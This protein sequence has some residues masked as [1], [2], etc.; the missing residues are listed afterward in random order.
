[1]LAVASGP[2][3]GEYSVDLDTGVYT[4]A[5]ADT[6]LGVLISYSYSVAADGQTFSISNTPMGNGPILSLYLPS[7]YESTGL[8]QL[9]RG[10]FLPNVR[11]GKLDLT[12]KLDD[13][14]MF[15]TDFEAFVNPS[16][17]IIMQSYLPY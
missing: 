10:I 8:A 11:F 7:P 4:F 15:D 16:T 14:E 9:D 12:T 3:T 2:T 13:Y 17:N 5:A 6:L 1:L